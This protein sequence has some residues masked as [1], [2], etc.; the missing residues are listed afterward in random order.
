MLRDLALRLLLVP[1]VSFTLSTPI[2]GHAESPPSQPGTNPRR[3]VES[4][5]S[6]ALESVQIAGA[7]SEGMTVNG[8]IPGPTLH[9]RVGDLARIHVTNTMNVPSSVHW[10]WH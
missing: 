5:L 6:I 9:W 8:S 3:I 10:R 4:E 7:R 1:L 2:P